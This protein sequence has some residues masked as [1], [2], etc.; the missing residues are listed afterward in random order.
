MVRGALVFGTALLL[1]AGSAFAQTPTDTAQKGEHKATAKAGGGASDQHFV[2]DAAKGGLAEVELGQLA[3]QKA[4]SDQV[5][6][7]AQRM[8][9]DHGKAN[10]ELKS[11]AQSKQIT[12]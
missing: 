11:L 10:D 1:S 7:F 3:S 12:L 4:S 5:K 6:Q 8:V 2:M 9:T